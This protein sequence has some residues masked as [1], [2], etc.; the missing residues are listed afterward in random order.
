ML[1]LPKIVERQAEPFIALRTHVAMDEIDKRAPDLIKA[2][3]DGLALRS[4]ERAGPL[5]FKYNVIDMERELEID[6]GVTL[7]SS[8]DI[9]GFITG[10]LPAG[11]YASLTYF[12]PFDDLYEV[13][14]I[15]V[16]WARQRGLRFD[17]RETPLGD[18]FSSRLEIYKTDP[19]LE[20][21]NSKWETELAFRLEDPSSP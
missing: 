10:M 15:M 18:A 14:A 8:T 1:T 4:I 12:G 16:G 6:I 9:A 5:F 11:R 21:D 19:A 2:L 7:S 17:V 3:Y 20:P 13:T